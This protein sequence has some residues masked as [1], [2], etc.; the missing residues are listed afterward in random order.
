[1]LLA[2]FG[3][4]QRKGVAEETFEPG[5]EA[6][7]G[8]RERGPE[9][10]FRLLRGGGQESEDR[11]HVLSFGFAK[12]LGPGGIKD[13]QRHGRDDVGLGLIAHAILEQ[14]GKFSGNAGCDHQRGRQSDLPPVPDFKSWSESLNRADGERSP[15]GQASQN[16]WVLVPE[17]TTAPARLRTNSPAGARRWLIPGATSPWWSAL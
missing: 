9:I 7:L 16:L 6:G 2:K 8:V 12:S 11:I 5:G 10:G 17:P 1:M 3:I 4:E 14:G 13:N 15:S